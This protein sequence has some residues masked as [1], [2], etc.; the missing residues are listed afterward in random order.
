MGYKSATL[1]K[2]Y[3]QRGLYFYFLFNNT[4]T[5]GY[6]SLTPFRQDVPGFHTGDL[7]NNMTTMGYKPAIPLKQY[8]QRGLYFF[9]PFNNITTE[10]ATPLKQDVAVSHTGDIPLNNITA[11][12][13]KS[14]THP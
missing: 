2:Q 10:S 7:I 3:A 4:T 5:E 1:L 9:F 12:G 11:M 8:A 13:Y 14:A 6:K